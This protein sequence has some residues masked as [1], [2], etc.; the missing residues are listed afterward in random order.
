VPGYLL[1]TNIIPAIRVSEKPAGA[2]VGADDLAVSIRT[3]EEVY[4][5]L[6][7]D[8]RQ[9]IGNELLLASLPTPIEL[10]DEVEDLAQ[11][12]LVAY[13]THQPPLQ[14]DD[15]VIAATAL[16]H[17]RILV[18]K[19]FR[20]FHYVEDLRWVDAE[21]VTVKAVSLLERRCAVVGRPSRGD[22]CQGLRPS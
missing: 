16:L 10:D 3:V 5:N 12:L 19:N 4:E 13:A 21:G 11:R 8:S 7:P 18:T 6:D 9:F 2:W 17:D 1:D 22:C 14:I 20:D 15:A